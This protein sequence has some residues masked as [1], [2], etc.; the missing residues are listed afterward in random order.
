VSAR[1]IL[2]CLLV[3]LALAACG[4]G[5]SSTSV[6]SPSAAFSRPTG[7]YVLP[8]TN[9]GPDSGTGPTLI[10]QPFIDGW[11]MRFGWTEIETAPGAYNWLRLDS[12]IAALQSSGKKLTLSVFP[13]AVPADILTQAGVTQYIADTATGSTVTTAVPWDETAL[14]RWEAFCKAL[15]DHQVA[16][17]SQG[18]VKVALRDHPVLA[19]VDAQ[20]VGLGGLRDL[21]GKLAATSSYTRSGFTTAAVRSIHAM[22][23]NFPSKYRYLAFFNMTDNDSSPTPLYQDMLNTLMAEFNAGATPVLGFYQENL[24][25]STPD[26]STA[27]AI[28]TT[29]DK[30]FSMF[31]MIYSWLTPPP[32]TTETNSCLLTTVPGD[33][34]TAYSGPEVAIDYAYN[35]F[36][37]RYF[38]V[39]RAD[40]E[41]SGFTSAF[42]ARHAILFP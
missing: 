2:P 22:A 4:S 28:Y 33:N 1:N 13:Q 25:C 15:G 9:E 6:I 27:S 34:T 10:A 35:T 32:N 18:G 36:G 26:T 11:V 38:E 8:N 41:N 16:D 21:H 14:S 37:T 39:Y 29:R 17:A 31:Q 23:D 24:G 5:A 20:I 19:Q 7:I 30:T 40:L 42:T 12:A 3:A